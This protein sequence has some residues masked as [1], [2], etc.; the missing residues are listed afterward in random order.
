MGK[1]AEGWKFNTSFMSNEEYFE[2]LDYDE[3]RLLVDNRQE[4]NVFLEFKTVNHPNYNDKNKNYDKEYFSKCLSGFANSNGGIVIWGVSADKDSNGIDCANSIK[5]IKQLTKLL[6]SF[7]SLEGQAVTP[8]I[9]GVKYKKIDIGDDTGFIV[10]YIPESDSSPHM[11]NL[12]DKH[13]YKRNGDSF[14]RAEH[15]DIVDMFSRRKRPSLKI[16]YKNLRKSLVRG[17]A[18][19]FEFVISVLNEGKSIAKFPYL[20]LKVSSP[21][22]RETF[23]IDGNGFTG[24]KRN[25]DNLSY[26]FNYTGG[27]DIVIHPQMTLDVD[28]FRGEIDKLNSPSDIKIEYLLMAD[29]MD[30]IEDEFTIS[31][32][33]LIG[34]PI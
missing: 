11:A 8:T 33:E 18:F 1:K 19:R 2:K 28:K 7:N 15:F 29:G 3:I 22:E 32:E 17:V 27:S 23:G 25:R 31:K 16:E 14:Y 10:G 26:K 6:N 30:P 24:L 21:F 9:K 34:L 5:P 12:A 20:A 4:E 13:Y